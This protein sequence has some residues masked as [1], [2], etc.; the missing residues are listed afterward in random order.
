MLVQTITRRPALREV[1]AA[2]GNV[3]VRSDSK[4]D[5]PLK[6][7]ETC[8]YAGHRLRQFVGPYGGYQAIWRDPETGIYTGASESR[9][10]GQ[11]AE[12]CWLIGADSACRF[13][14]FLS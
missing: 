5:S 6:W 3:A 9:K 12:P 2:D 7:S 1:G 11:A 14:V 8:N 4:A 10:D 13:D